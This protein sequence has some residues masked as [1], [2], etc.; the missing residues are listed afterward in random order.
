MV[1]A[2]WPRVYLERGTPV[3][4]LAMGGGSNAHRKA[5]P[6]NVLVIRADGEQVVRPFRG[7]RKPTG[8]VLLTDVQQGAANAF[9]A[10]TLGLRG[11]RAP[12]ITRSGEVV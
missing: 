8:E 5:G 4:A 2:P 11:A 10:G 6:R 1:S 7:L 3:V 9:L 12:L